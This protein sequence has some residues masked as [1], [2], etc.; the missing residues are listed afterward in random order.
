ML[1]RALLVSLRQGF[2]SDPDIAVA[3]ASGAEFVFLGRAPMFGVCA[4]G[5]WER[6]ADTAV[7]KPFGH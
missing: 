7:P 4:L 6:V 2:R 3:L 1:E 5:G